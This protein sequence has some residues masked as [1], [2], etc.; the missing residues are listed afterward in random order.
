MLALRE[1][2]TKAREMFGAKVSVTAAS[3]TRKRKD[4]L[5]EHPPGDSAP[6]AKKPPPSN[7]IMLGA[8]DLSICGFVCKSSEVMTG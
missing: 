4:F 8:L 6:T 1:L 7:S 2:L 3:R 5:V